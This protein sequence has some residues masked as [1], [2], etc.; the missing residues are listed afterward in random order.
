MIA[1]IFVTNESEAAVVGVATSRGLIGSEERGES[2][3]LW[4]RESR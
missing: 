4:K 1:A 2:A 3:R